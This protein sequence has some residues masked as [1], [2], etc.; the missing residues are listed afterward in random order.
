MADA[1]A[2]FQE[3]VGGEFAEGG[4]QGVAAD[5]EGGGEL[6][7]A[8]ERV[9][10]D[11]AGDFD[12]KVIGGLADEGGAWLEGGQKMG[13]DSAHLNQSVALADHFGQARHLR[14][15]PGAQGGVGRVAHPQPD[16]HRSAR[17]R[18]H[19]L[20]KILIF[21][22]DDPVRG[23]GMSPDRAILRLAQSD[24]A[25]CLRVVTRLAQPACE[26]G[27]K[28]GVDQELHRAARVRTG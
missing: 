24:L 20:R 28:L 1:L 21:G 8:G 16:D 5:E 17:L 2:G 10:P 15:Q 9:A 18:L 14:E 23:L 6:A 12:A 26:R 4:A 13:V 19:P 7:F 11:T 25:H 22:D 3:A 27:R